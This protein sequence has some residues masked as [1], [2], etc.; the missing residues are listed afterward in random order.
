MTPKISTTGILIRYI[1]YFLIYIGV[2]F[3]PAGT[4]NWAEGW[5]FLIVLFSISVYM[6]LWLKK[7][8]PEL[9]QKRMTFMKKGVKKWD[10]IFI[11]GT[12]PIFIALVVVPGFDVVRY[13]WSKLPFWLEIIGLISLVASF[14]FIFWVMKENTYL[15]RFVE[16]QKGHKV[17]DTGPYKY[18]RHPMYSGVIV[19]IF[20]IP[21][22][23]GSL[24]TL[25]PAILSAIAVIIRL[26]FEES[27]L[28]KELEG[29]TEYTKKVKYRLLPGIW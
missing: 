21:L 14:L 6:T 24:Y 22:L 7:H 27:D 26:F 3:W 18:V 8:N 28:H 20:A 2:I 10:K 9:L 5:V 11:I 23:L 16:V 15:S 19:F 17:V 29:Y 4:V 1:V 13:G 25:I 12:I